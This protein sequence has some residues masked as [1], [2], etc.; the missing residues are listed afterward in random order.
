MHMT[1][2]LNT[3]ITSI[4]TSAY[5]DMI[6]EGRGWTVIQRNKNGSLVNFNRSWN[7][8][9]K[10][11]GD[12]NTEFWYGLYPISCLTHSGYWEM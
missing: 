2:M 3:V 11:F 4:K 8:Y 12:L 5:C 6:T 10:G 9:E 7:D 1:T